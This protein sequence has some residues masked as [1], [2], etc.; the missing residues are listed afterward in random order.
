MHAL[1]I[2]LTMPGVPAAVVMA[3]RKPFAPDRAET[4]RLFQLTVA[5]GLSVVPAGLSTLT[6]KLSTG[7][8]EQGYWAVGSNEEKNCV[9]VTGCE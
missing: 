4:A 1:T 8:E 2:I 5:V 7:Q 6:Q 9:N 3:T